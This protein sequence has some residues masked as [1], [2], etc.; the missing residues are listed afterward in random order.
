MILS[1]GAALM[2]VAFVVSALCVPLTQRMATRFGLLDRPGK[3]KQHVG[4]VPLLG[5]SAIFAGFLLPTM[6][7]LAVAAVW[8][9]DGVPAWVPRDL[10]VHISGIVAKATGALTILAAAFVLHVMGI[11]DDRRGL[12]PW[13][14]LGVQIAIALAVTLLAGLRVLTVLPAPLSITLTVLWLVIITNAFN[15]LD[16]MDGLATGVATIIAAALL[17]AATSVGQWFVA[18]W[19][20]LLLGALVGF[21]PF[22]FHPARSFMGDGGALVVGFLLA[23]LSILTTYVPLSANSLH[24]AIVPLVL[25]AVPLYD[26]VSV[27]VLRIRAR[28][29]PMVGDLRHFSHRLV[30]RGM[31]VRATVL[32]IYLCTAA[33]AVGASL[34]P[35]VAGLAG[36]MLVLMQTLAILGVIALLEAG[37]GR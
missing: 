28:Q 26:T 12:G 22:N 15:L 13:I 8:S 11:I 6:L 35:Y 37:N 19:L 9:A 34:L 32:T 30:R 18:A 10:A 23:V 1:L 16:N 4:A 25:M 21:L 2:V 3:H 7:G 33:T 31:S 20:C 17:A 27:I 5:G 29:H 24:A 36:A 14:K